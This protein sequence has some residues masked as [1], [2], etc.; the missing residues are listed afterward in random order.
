MDH[1]SLP[2]FSVQYHPEA[3]PGPHEND[4]H[5]DR[6]L[7]LAAAEAGFTLPSAPA[8]RAAGGSTHAAA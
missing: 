7:R 5:F 8:V 1:R 6:F 4:V 3:A 2:V